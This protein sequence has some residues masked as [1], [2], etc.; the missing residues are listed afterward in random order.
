MAYS[1]INIV[2]FNNTDRGS[3]VK[4]TK[5]NF[6]Q[7]ISR[8][9]NKKKIHLNEYLMGSKSMNILEEVEKRLEKVD[10]YRKDANIVC[11][12]CLC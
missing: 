1:T 5:H 10:K 9:V 6:R 2:K 7:E 3:I 12:V 8:N 4:V 11:N